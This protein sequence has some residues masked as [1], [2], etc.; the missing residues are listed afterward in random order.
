VIE[1]VITDAE[2]FV[3]RS[4][5]IEDGAHQGR[6]P[7]PPFCAIPLLVGTLTI[8]TGRTNILSGR[9]HLVLFAPFLFLVFAP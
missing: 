4:K 3:V 5:Q 2:H 7:T 1:K 6:V 9:A 8:G